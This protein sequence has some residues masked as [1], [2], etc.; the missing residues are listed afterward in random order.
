V[1]KFTGL[2]RQYAALREE[3]VEAADQV[4]LT[5]Q[6]LDGEFTA[7]FEEEIAKRCQ[8]KY[9]IAVNSGTQALIFAQ[10]AL[11]LTG[12]VTIPT[13][14]FAATLN[15]VVSAGL[16]PVYSETSVPGMMFPKAYATDAIM[17]VNLFGNVLDY[18]RLRALNPN[19]PIIEDA[20][21]SFGAA[22]EAGPSGKLG[23]VSVLS[24]DPTKNL[25]NYGSGGMVLTDDPAVAARVC[26]LRN[27]GKESGHTVAGTNSKMSEVDCAQM[28]V[29]L[30]HFDQWQKRRHEIA[31][32]YADRICIDALP[33]LPGMLVTHAWHKYVIRTRNRNQLQQWLGS[34][35][36][37]T[38]IH[39]AQA[40]SDLAV[41]PVTNY[42]PVTEMHKATAL[43]LPIYPELTDAEVE[44]VAASVNSFFR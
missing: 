35:D 2:G 44:Y 33:I 26:N 20:A 16:V 13:I 22:S 21:Q 27:N 8:R 9:A 23:T 4:L 25:P 11:G 30:G 3:L 43:S 5:G 6:V 1:I 24:F 42:C 18:N 15:S 32:Y 29:K 34:K 19:T 36:I 7:R 38:K 10:Q 14:S 12:T 40:L 17:Y 31:D 37:E 39:Y 28:L 41:S